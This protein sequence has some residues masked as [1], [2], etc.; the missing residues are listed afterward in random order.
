MKPLV[1]V[2][3]PLYNAAP[4]IGE[5]LES[6]IVSTYRPMEVVV[7]DDGSTDNS[8]S[9]AQDIAKRHPEIKGLHQPNAGVSAA[10]NH[11][12]R[13]AKGTFILPLDADAPP[14]Y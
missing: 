3:V 12:I 14:S 1:S 9:I 6:V 2:I 10:R 7:V 8:L 13:E 11:A 5:A 4:F